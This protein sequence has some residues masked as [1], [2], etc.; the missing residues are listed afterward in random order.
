MD[1]IDLAS[2]HQ[3]IDAQSHRIMSARTDE[4]IVDQEFKVTKQGQTKYDPRDKQSLGM[5]RTMQENT[6]EDTDCSPIFQPF[7]VWVS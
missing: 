2:I 4:L 1:R 6:R 7:R 5:M 3:D